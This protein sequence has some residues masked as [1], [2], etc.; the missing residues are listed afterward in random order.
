MVETKIGRVLGVLLPIILATGCGSNE[1]KDTV[2]VTG[3]VTN[4]ETLAE[5]EVNPCSGQAWSTF[6]STLHNVYFRRH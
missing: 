3:L 6:D 2:T 1:K 5:A 4:G